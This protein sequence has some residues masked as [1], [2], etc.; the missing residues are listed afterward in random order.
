MSNNHTEEVRFPTLPFIHIISILIKRQQIMDPWS[1]KSANWLFY[2]VL[3]IVIWVNYI[4]QSQRIN[5]KPY[6][7]Y[8]WSLT[9][10]S[11]RAHEFTPF[12]I[13]G[14]AVLIFFAFCILLLCL[15]IFVF[16]MCP[17]FLVFLDCPFLT[18]VSFVLR[19]I[20][21]HAYLYAVLSTSYQYI[22]AMI[23]FSQ[24]TLC[25]AVNWNQIHF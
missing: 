6:Y 25:L 7:T 15:V 13:D 2:F 5:Q 10:L 17:M 9:F 24:I 4:G 18:I 12:F 20:S 14:S 8:I 23:L 16:V 1:L 22:F 19:V 3:D 11:S 21:Y